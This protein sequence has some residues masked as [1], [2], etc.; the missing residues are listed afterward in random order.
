MKPL[1]ASWLRREDGE[2]RKEEREGTFDRDRF[3]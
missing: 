1:V 2:R 3:S